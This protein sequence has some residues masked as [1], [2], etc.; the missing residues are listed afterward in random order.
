MATIVH[1][2]PAN[3]DSTLWT[4]EAFADIGFLLSPACL[5]LRSEALIPSIPRRTPCRPPCPIFIP[6]L[7]RHRLS[8]GSALRT[9]QSL[10]DGR[11]PGCARRSR[12]FCGSSPVGIGPQILPRE[13]SVMRG[14]DPLMGHLPCRLDIHIPL[15]DPLSSSPVYG[16]GNGGLEI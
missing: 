8:P 15:Q 16:R 14:S 3:S 10:G 12:R 1:W 5:L 7:S 6:S 2:P 13:P 4:Q 11:G 9:R